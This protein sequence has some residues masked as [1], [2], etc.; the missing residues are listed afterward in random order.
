MVVGVKILT[1][2]LVQIWPLVSF[3]PVCVNASRRKS[4]NLLLQ[5]V[6][7]PACVS[8]CERAKKL[9]STFHSHKMREA[10]LSY[11]MFFL[12]I[13]SQHEQNFQ[14]YKGRQI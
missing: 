10:Q 2:P 12:H 13:L 7:G 8:D 5:T 14:I 9:L 4:I 3:I 1:N 11:Q 6:I